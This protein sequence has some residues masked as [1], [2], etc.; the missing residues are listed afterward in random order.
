MSLP[1]FQSRR[2][3]NSA[4]RHSF[5]V[6]NLAWFA[7]KP[8]S[9]LGPKASGAFAGLLSVRA[10]VWQ[11][12][13]TTVTTPF[14]LKAHMWKYSCVCQGFLFCFLSQCL[15]NPQILFEVDRR[16]AGLLTLVRDIGSSMNQPAS[17]RDIL[18]N[19]HQSERWGSLEP[20]AK[21]Q[22]HSCLD[23]IKRHKESIRAILTF[24]LD[25][26]C[27]SWRWL[28][29]QDFWSWHCNVALPDIVLHTWCQIL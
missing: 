8:T 13:P 18:R 19:R 16:I 28:I 29:D 25:K 1:L 5:I 12:Y 7:S 9:H 21:L 20:R 11:P 10:I 22:Q 6:L 2:A 26:G 3:D 4:C 14:P 23:K 24:E 17:N 27:G 15:N